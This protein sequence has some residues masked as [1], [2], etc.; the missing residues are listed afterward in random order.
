MSTMRISAAI[1]LLARL[2]CALAIAAPLVCQDEA[3]PYFAISSAR[4]FG[5]TETPVI[6]LSGWQVDA[7]Q[8]RA[9]RIRDPVKFFSDLQE[10]HGFGSTQPRAGRSR[11][12]LERIH[13]WKRSARRR[14]RVDLR[15]QFTESPSAH[16]KRLFPGKPP[17]VSQNR[18]TYFADAPVLNQDQLLLSFIQPLNSKTSWSSSTVPIPVKNKG[19]FLVE[20]VHGNLRAY[21]ILMVSDIVL[22]TKAGRDHVLGWV[23]DRVT[24]EPIANASIV[25]MPPKAEPVRVATD[26]NGVAEFPA[27]SAAAEDL[28]MVAA[29]GADFALNDIGSWTF[30]SRTRNWTGYIYTE[31]P[32]YRP[33]DAM[34]FRGILRQQAAVGYEIPVNQGVSVQI[35]DPDSKPVYQ[36]TLTTT[37]NGI[38]HD[39]FAVPK[40]APLGNYWI[41]VKAG[42]SQMNGNFEVQEY[43]KPEYEV[44]VTPAT[45]RV[46]EGES[47]QA[48]IDAR[49]YF[50]EPVAN[51][52][53]K[54]SVYRSRYWFP[55][56]Y[57]AD[58]ES[59]G[60]NPG[61]Q[62]DDAS[63]ELITQA[64]GR[65]DQEGKLQVTIPTTVSD[66]KIDYRYRVQA[67]V[68]DKAGRGISGSG[69]VIATYGS[70]VLNVTPDRYFFEPST[71]ASFKVEARDYDNKPVSTTPVH[72]ELVTWDWR[73]RNKKGEIRSHADART[74]A[75][76]AATTELRIPAEGGSYRVIATARSPENRTVESE[77]YIWVSSENEA[78]LWGGPEGAVQI[79]PDKKTYQPGDTAKLLVVT[80]R[81]KTPVLVTIE[82]RDIRSKTVL[83][84]QGATAL[85]QYTV[86]QDDEPGFFV[87]AQFIRSGQLYQGQ[88]RVKVPPLDH[89]LNVKLSTDKPQYLPGQGGVYKIDVTDCNGK[90]AAKADLSLGVVDE[91]VYAIRPDNMPD[92]A[93]FFYGREWNSV[94]TDNS[95]T[96]FF[97]GEAGTRRMRL[98]EL[99]APTQLAQLKPERLVQPKVRKAFPDTAFWAADL[100]TDSAGHAQARVQFPDSLTTWRATARGVAPGDRFGQAVLKTIVRKNLIVRLA[101]PRFFVQGDEVVISALIHNYLQTAKHARVRVQI[102]GLDILDGATTQEVN[103]ASRGEAKI[104]WRVK[105]QI[106]RQAKITAEALTDEE[107]DALELDLPIHPPG[108]PV[109]QA[110]SGSISD[111]GSTGFSFTFPA[112][113]VP[114]SRSLSVHLSSSI[115]GSIFGALQYLTSFPYGCVEQT[116]SSFL[117]DIMVSKAVT[118][119]GL[120][121]PIDPSDLNQKIQAG[122]DRL[123][124]FQHDDGGWG[125]WVNDGSHPFMT[126]YVV[127]GLSEARE[128]GIAVRSESI[129]HGVTWLRKALASD[130]QLAPDLRAYVGYA[131]ALAGQP[132]T[133][134]LNALD[135]NKSKLSPYGSAL[136]GLA[137]DSIKDSRSAE[138]AS[139]LEKTAR[140]N[141]SEAW[142]PARRDE[143]LDFTADVTPESTAYAMK[144]ISRQYPNSAVL[145]KAALWLV[146]HR[147]EG[148]WWSST[149]QTAMVIY[150]LVDYL[151][152][153]NEL[154]PDFTATVAVNGQ[155]AVTH[156]FN[157]DGTPDTEV[158]LDEAKLESGANQIQVNSQGQGRLYYSIAAIHNSN[159]ARF[160][161]QGAISLNLLRDYFRL[162]PTKT[163]DHIVYELAPV[164]GTVAQG[165]TIAVRLT[166]TGS[167]WRYLMVEDPIPAGTEFIEQ[168]NLYQIANKPPWWQYWF[169][170]RE[171]HDNRMAI[172]QT[173]FNEGQQQYFYLLKVV[174][175][176]LFHVSPARVQPMYQPE[177]QATTEARTLEVK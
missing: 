128:E 81:A 118:E 170:R 132:D 74:D 8:I 120:K 22:L 25:G 67:E 89:E 28:R 31:R 96:Y 151:K 175:P 7:V 100:T 87:S 16:L 136:L 164:E 92:I 85:F 149:K 60:L 125:W 163:G 143:M 148:Y 114:G 38:I 117:P 98:A 105:A 19:L 23:A 142:W 48:A 144:L 171:L 9:Y 86:S 51:A 174:N 127:A 41:Q 69:S 147:D 109:R 47:V 32:V 54:Y 124:S 56:W 129:E 77:N 137:F 173:Y 59:E 21:T 70:F 75:S 78:S 1:A 73:N 18:A 45:P 165:D 156:T 13:N 12:L 83:R 161:K 58:E 6:M 20:A 53:V 122:L 157:S 102:E 101:V 71:T 152:T 42:E 88:K 10:P 126:A 27:P 160:E 138:L 159:Q 103:V 141:E 97:N 80:G 134:A 154:H 79:V 99:R 153:T 104:D 145:P 108:V 110:K 130:E 93:S 3:R 49:Y 40:N 176:G 155:A 30:S 5:S 14:I 106:A 29:H 112:D 91:A 167:D 166:V 123:Y 55:L 37:A 63:S 66:H 68:T 139:Q 64:E 115:A 135:K 133:G 94:Y 107:S 33:G 36:K 4:T 57:D 50:G 111:S 158:V 82:G 169:T 26:A 34:H 140:Q 162:V 172:F 62:Y 11:T 2:A 76:G 61:D 24:G 119:L 72:L 15:S 43:K 177:H 113:S 84:S 116:M 46:L 90:P 95:L 150:G 121:E 168:D 35:A 52:K 146:N 131:L 17:V 39:D 65:L 44:R